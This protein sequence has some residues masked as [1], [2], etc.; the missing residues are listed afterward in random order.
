MMNTDHLPAYE[1]DFPAWADWAQTENGILPVAVD[2]IV[3]GSSARADDYHRDWSNRE[4]FDL[5]YDRAFAFVK[6]RLSLPGPI[7]LG[8]IH[9]FKFDDIYYVC[10]DGHR[11]VSAAH[12][13]GI[14]T[15]LADVTKLFPGY[16]GSPTAREK[17]RHFID[18][19][20]KYLGKSEGSV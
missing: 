9:L 12:V 3:G 11:R 17:A 15:I 19:A 4:I 20:R 18:L 2:H 5:R 13:L 16:L 10:M 6:E 14:K 8:Y 1:L 7:D